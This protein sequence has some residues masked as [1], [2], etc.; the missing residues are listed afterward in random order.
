M[1][2][3]VVTAVEDGRAFMGTMVEVYDAD[4][5]FIAYTKTDMD[6]VYTTPGL[7]TG[8]YK[9]FFPGSSDYRP[10]D[11]ISTWNGDADTFE[12]A[13]SISVSAPGTVAGINAAL[14]QGGK[15]S[16]Y[17]HEAGTGWPLY[18]TLVEF[19]HATDGTLADTAW[20]NPWGYYESS[21][22]PGDDYVVAFSKEGYL[23]RWYDDAG[24]QGSAMSVSVELGEL[25]TGID[26]YLDALGNR[27]FLP[28]VLRAH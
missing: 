7:P 17:V 9:V 18:T 1:I 15:V 5:T 22:L 16:G 8:D 25:V 13:P 11:Y 19:Y 20:T 23:T 6:G 24:D 4:Q 10:S 26:V 12:T 2:T 27:V 14:V 21:G 28:L 3:G